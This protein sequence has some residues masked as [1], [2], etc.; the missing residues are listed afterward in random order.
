M[1]TVPAPLAGVEGA[2][3]EVL[4]GF[5]DQRQAL[6]AGDAEE[7]HAA[8]MRLDGLVARL[9]QW[10]PRGVGRPV[11]EAGSEQVHG[12]LVALRQAASLNAGLLQRRAAHVRAAVEHF[13]DAAPALHRQQMGATY[14]PLGAGASAPALTRP[15]GRA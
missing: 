2:L 12:L 13:A 15:L 9:R 10:L 11:A 7:V 4:Q 8:T 6:L 3:A 14:A 1:N 5:E